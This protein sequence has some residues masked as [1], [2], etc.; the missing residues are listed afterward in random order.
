MYRIM[1]KKALAP[2]I[3][4]VR[5]HAP[6]VAEAAKPGQFLI[7]VACEKSERIPLT[8]ADFN[9]EDG[10][11]TIVFQKMGKG[12]HKIAAFDEG[13]SLHAVLGPQGNPTHAG[14][15]EHIVMIGGGIGV[16]PV[17]PIARYM[18]SLGKKVTSIIG[19]RGADFLFW[20]D[21]LADVSS[22]LKI[23][24]NDGSVGTK[25]F[26]TDVLRDMIDN[27]ET[28]DR[29][30][31]IGPPVMMKAVA[32][33]TRPYS[34]QTTVS[35]NSLMVCGI[36]MCGACR[37]TVGGEVRFTCMDGPEFDAHDVDFDE[38][39]QRLSM[40]KNEEVFMFDAYKDSCNE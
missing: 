40:Y 7:I 35:L 1:E 34:I 23:A 21:R 37:V 9:R 8:I 22:E 4:M 3:E 14:S 32:D 15:E 16:A 10:S 12:T 2:Q 28:I 27:G 39:V 18:S 11:V 17:Y 19:Y 24:T 13:D 20:D 33:M 5:I 6:L 26:V 30:I 29:V 38:L 36:G 25:G 31:A